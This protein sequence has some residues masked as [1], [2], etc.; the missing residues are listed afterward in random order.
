MLRLVGAG[1]GCA[2]VLAFVQLPGT[3]GR[4][5]AVQLQ[6]LWAWSLS[7]PAAQPFLFGVWGLTRP[8]CGLH[9]CELELSM[10]GGCVRRD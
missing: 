2:Y 8:G 4:G 6:A 7:G 5:G 1:D 10:K 3:A 9:A